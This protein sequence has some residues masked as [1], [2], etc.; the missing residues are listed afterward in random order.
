MLSRSLSAVPLRA[1]VCKR[2]DKVLREGAMPQVWTTCD[3][4][5][6]RLSWWDEIGP[7]LLAILGIAIVCGL[8]AWLGTGGGF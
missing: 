8:W 4:C 1:V 2:C 5:L 7:E 6:A 3:A